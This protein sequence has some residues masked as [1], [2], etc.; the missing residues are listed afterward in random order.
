MTINT[1]RHMLPLGWLPLTEAA[2]KDGFHPVHRRLERDGQKII[3]KWGYL[4]PDIHWRQG[5]G[6]AELTLESAY[7]LELLRSSA[8]TAMCHTSHQDKSRHACEWSPERIARQIPDFGTVAQ[9]WI[10]RAPSA[11]NLSSPT[12]PTSGTRSEWLATLPLLL[13]SQYRPRLDLLMRDPAR[14][15]RVGY[16]MLCREWAVHGQSRHQTAEALAIIGLG[17]VGLFPRVRCAVCYRMAMPAITR[18]SRHSQTQSIRFDDD[19]PKVHAQISSEARLAKRVMAKLGWAPN[20]F[21]TD[22]GYD[23][24]VEEKTIGG[25][26][27]GLHVG[28]GGYTLQRLRDGLSAG[29]FPLVRALLP[30]NFCELDD[31]RACASLRR[32]IDPGEWVVS[33][34]FTRVGA[35]EAWLEAAEAL[36]HGR[37]HMKPT[38]QNRERV[39]KAR[40]L[41][42]QGMSK[43]NIA[44]QLGISQSH[45]SHLLRRH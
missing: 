25:L 45:L 17:A 35:A 27:W 9:A 3:D 1:R 15:L 43:K 12:L 7:T 10:S 40:A 21:L 16:Q 42:Q 31:A 34:W 23:G 13:P 4:T 44:S 11:I 18:C 26:L 6:K 19:E 36:P 2:R 38:D 32:R 24:F 22:F 20:D 30:S 39:A 14:L 37:A 33:Y 41:L 8:E 29:H 28:D 5:R